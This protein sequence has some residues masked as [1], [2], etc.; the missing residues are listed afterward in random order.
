MVILPAL[1][2]SDVIMRSL[3]SQITGAPTVYS[4]VWPGAY[5]RK[6][7]ISASLAFV[8]GE[9]PTQRAS[10]AEYVCIWWRHHGVEAFDSFT[11]NIQG[12]PTGTRIM[13]RLPRCQ[14][15]N[16]IIWVNHSEPQWTTAMGKSCARFFWKFCTSMMWKHKWVRTEF[17]HIR[18]HMY[19]NRME[20]S[21]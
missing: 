5:Q 11:N 6:Y 4:I 21:S 13:L 14:W 9:F 15:G 10:N 1:H 19:T 18:I 17:I 3:T 20:T 16:S 8:T 7:Q 2:N 12:C